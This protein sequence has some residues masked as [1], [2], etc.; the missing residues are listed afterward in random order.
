MNG[1]QSQWGCQLGGGGTWQLPPTFDPPSNGWVSGWTNDA[2]CTSSQGT[3]SQSDARWLKQ[4]IVDDGTNNP[5]FSYPTTAMAGWLCRS[6]VPNNDYNCTTNYN[7]KYCA[8]N[9]SP[10]GQIFYA[11]ITA[12][13]AQPTNYNIYAVDGC[14]GAEG[15]G[16]GNVPGYGN[17]SLTG[18]KAVEQDMAGPLGQQNLGQCKHP[19]Q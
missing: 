1:Q 14:V 6:V 16:Q 12:G 8:N 11:A 5:V 18:L 17:G 15:V 7:W 19:Q 10:Q 3:S 9:S 4:S 2:S 13:G